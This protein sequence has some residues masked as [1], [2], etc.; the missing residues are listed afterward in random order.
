MECRLRNKNNWHKFIDSSPQTC[1][2]THG[3][4]SYFGI[5]LPS[6]PAE[7]FLFLFS[8]NPRSYSSHGATMLQQGGKKTTSR[9]FPPAVRAGGEV[10]WVVGVAGRRRG[11]GP[12]SRL[13]T[14]ASAADSQLET[15]TREVRLKHKFLHTGTRRN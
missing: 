1:I 8:R 2:P 14:E 10:G 6:L 12:G 9:V 7:K 13:R 11:G 3:K 4:E 5:L 15:R